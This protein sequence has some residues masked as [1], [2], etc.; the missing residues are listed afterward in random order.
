MQAAFKI[1]NLI[2]ASFGGRGIPFWGL[3]NNEKQWPDNFGLEQF[4]ALG[5]KFYLPIGFIIAGEQLQLP[6]EPSMTVDLKKNIVKTEL[7]GNTRK[8]SVKELINI[9]D[10][11]ITIQGICYDHQRKSYPFEQVKVLKKIFEYKGSIEIISGLTSLLEIKYVVA[12][13]LSLP[14]I[15]GRPYSQPYTLSLISDEDFLLI[16]D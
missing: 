9:D 14:A 7:T 5:T 12:E 2:P 11:I 3:P 1:E 8:G 6:W 16:Q 4:S 10:F 15:N 13:S